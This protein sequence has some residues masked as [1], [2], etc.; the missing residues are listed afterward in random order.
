MKNGENNIT[1]IALVVSLFI[2]CIML[3]IS[4]ILLIFPDWSLINEPYHDLEFSYYELDLTQNES[5]FS[6]KIDIVSRDGK[7][8]QTNSSR[9]NLER[10]VDNVQTDSLSVADYETTKKFVKHIQ[11]YSYNRD[12]IPPEINFSINFSISITYTDSDKD[13]YI[14]KG[15]Y[16]ILKIK[17][18][19]KN[20]SFNLSQYHYQIYYFQ[21]FTEQNTCGRITLNER[22]PSPYDPIVMSET[23]SAEGPP[24]CP[25]IFITISIILIGFQL[26]F[27]SKLIKDRKDKTS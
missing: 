12:R 22:P 17:D 9:L 24:L 25:T 7:K 6:Y 2:V 5:D 4:I 18:L 20:E 16:F 1:I 14:S 23:V 21:I 10:L 11:Y 3:I 13:E 27:L 26:Y 19:D 8:V 15:D